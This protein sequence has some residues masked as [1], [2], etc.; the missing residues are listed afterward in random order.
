MISW[1][2][3][4]HMSRSCCGADVLAPH[5]VLHALQQ[6][7]RPPRE[8]AQLVAC[9]AGRRRRARRC[10]GRPARRARCSDTA[11]ARLV[12]TVMRRIRPISITQPG[13]RDREQHRRRR[14]TTAASPRRSGSGRCRAASPVSAQL[15]A[16]R[17]AS[18]STSRAASASRT[19][20][21]AGG[22]SAARSAARSLPAASSRP[23]SVDQRRCAAAPTLRM[24]SVSPGSSAG[25]RS[26][27][28]NGGIAPG[29]VAVEH[30]ARPRRARASRM[31][32]SDAVEVRRRPYRAR[33]AIERLA[34]DVD[35][36]PD[37][38]ERALRAVGAA[39]RRRRRS[40]RSA[41]ASRGS[42]ARG[43]RSRRAWAR[44]STKP[45]SRPRTT[46]APRLG[47]RSNGAIQR[48]VSPRIVERHARAVHVVEV[49]RA[50]ARAA[51][52]SPRREAA[53]EVDEAARIGVVADRRRTA[54]LP[55]RY[56]TEQPAISTA[57]C[58]LFWSSKSSAPIGQ[59]AAGCS[60]VTGRPPVAGFSSASWPAGWRSLA[61]ISA[62]VLRKPCSVVAVAALLLVLQQH[63]RQRER[64]QREQQEHAAEEDAAAKRREAE[65]RHC[66]PRQR[67]LHQRPSSAPAARP[68]GS[69]ASARSRCRRSRVDLA[70][71][72]A[73]GADVL[74]HVVA[75]AAALHHVEE[76]VVRHHFAARAVAASRGCAAPSAAG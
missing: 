36:Q 14:T 20:P 50:A 59:H 31:R 58:A 27:S 73:D 12:S 51:T 60:G 5:V 17:A 1:P 66:Q 7:D 43:S 56:C 54:E 21:P 25:A 62:C 3:A 18:R 44:S 40:S 13:Q 74:A 2:T 48:V 30:A 34:E 16:A 57:C 49:E 24:R 8:D 22:G 72:V 33:L 11:A 6:V 38:E 65:P 15:V 35:R 29:G 69:R 28:E 53:D 63:Q 52:S 46:G 45:V 76:L 42:R 71:G 55:S 70:E 10:A 32:T 61:T 4:C 39:R 26:S 23:L 19:R 75:V 64:R 67:Q 9:R 68:S 37:R 41:T 47:Q